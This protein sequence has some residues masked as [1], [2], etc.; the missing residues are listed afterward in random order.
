M[1]EN[2]FVTHKEHNESISR[3]HSRIDEIKESSIRQEGSSKRQEESSIRIE[4]FG[5]DI[6]DVI[7]G[8]DKT[9]GLLTRVSSNIKLIQ[10]NFRLVLGLIASMSVLATGVI[11]WFIK[12]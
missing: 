11:I 12:K 4:R 3:L 7:Y 10:I 6:H 5:K 2:T 1:P 9:D 8:T